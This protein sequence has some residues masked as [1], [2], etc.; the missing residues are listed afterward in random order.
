[1]LKFHVDT[2]TFLKVARALFSMFSSSRLGNTFD[3]V[4]TSCFASLLCYI[5]F[6]NPSAYK[7]AWNVTTPKTLK[8][9][10]IILPS[11]Q[12]FLKLFI[13]CYQSWLLL[14]ICL[15]NC[16]WYGLEECPCT[17]RTTAQR[18]VA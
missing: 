6:I 2:K 18:I 10:C 9:V 1:M 14:I 5:V 15:V 7:T 13:Q 12:Q 11:V 4:P 3:M 8:H 17:E 16:Y